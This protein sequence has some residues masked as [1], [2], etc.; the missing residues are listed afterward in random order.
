MVASMVRQPKLIEPRYQSRLGHS[1]A[2]DF[3]L[4]HCSH[5]ALTHNHHL[6]LDYRYH[7][8]LATAV[9]P[10]CNPDHR[11]LPLLPAPRHRTPPND[12]SKHQLR[13][14]PEKAKRYH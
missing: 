3:F 1:D 13:R 7:S 12:P 11:Q 8:P 6:P 2:T 9:V 4:N 5:V 10:K 14:R